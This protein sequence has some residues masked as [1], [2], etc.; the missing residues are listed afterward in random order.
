MQIHIICLTLNCITWKQ[1]E[2]VNLKYWPIFK[3]DFNFL[4]SYQKVIAVSKGFIATIL[5]ELYRHAI[6]D[7]QVGSEFS[8]LSISQW[9]TLHKKW[10][11]SLR[12]SSINVT[13]SAGNCE[14]GH[15]Y[16]RN[17]S[18]KTSFFCAVEEK[19]FFVKNFVIVK[20]NKLQLRT[21]YLRQTLVFMWNSALRE[22]FN[23]CFSGVFCYYWLWIYEVLRFLWYS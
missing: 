23:F 11:F 18:W 20:K 6:W 9:R 12:N 16:W 19:E 5:I 15:I 3:L 1:M 14:F 21:K 13:K 8:V 7:Y 22:K 4:S 17:P 10:S 2:P